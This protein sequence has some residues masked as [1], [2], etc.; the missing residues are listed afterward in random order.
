[1][2]AWHQKNQEGFFLQILAKTVHAN[3]EHTCVINERFLH[4]SDQLSDAD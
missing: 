1:M 4:A 2:S 3:D